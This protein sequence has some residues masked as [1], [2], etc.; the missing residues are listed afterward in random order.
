M[1][2]IGSHGFLLLKLAERAD[3]HR[4]ARAGGLR[5]ARVGILDLNDQPLDMGR[6]LWRDQALFGEMAAD[7]IDQLGALADQDIAGS[8]DRRGG[9]LGLALHSHVAPCWSLRG[10]AD[11]LGVRSIVLL[12]HDHRLH[13]AGTIT[14][15]VWPSLRISRPQPCALGQATMATG[16]SSW[17]GKRASI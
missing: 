17:A 1:P 16:Q 6:P 12:E 10:L 14:F 5:H 9:L 7:H 11:R 8:V 3:E 4:E 15:T 2:I 13:V